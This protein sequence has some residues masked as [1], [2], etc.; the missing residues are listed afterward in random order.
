[1]PPPPSDLLSNSR[2]VAYSELFKRNPEIVPPN[3]SE[4]KSGQTFQRHRL[5]LHG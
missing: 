1:M 4:M 5:Y 3:D 2:T